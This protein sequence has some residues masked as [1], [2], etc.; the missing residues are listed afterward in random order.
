MTTDTCAS[1][2]TKL[3]TMARGYSAEAA[4]RITES[5]YAAIVESRES[6]RLR[7][8]RKETVF[9]WVPEWFTLQA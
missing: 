3:T 5:Q 7:L 8:A 4:A 6:F 9:K 1:D 2:N